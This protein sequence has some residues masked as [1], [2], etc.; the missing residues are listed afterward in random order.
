MVICSFPFLDKLGY[1]PACGL[2]DVAYENAE[3]YRHKFK[4]DVKLMT[5][6]I[7]YVPKWYSI[8]IGF[9]SL[10]VLTINPFSYYKYFVNKNNLMGHLLSTFWLLISLYYL[11]LFIVEFINA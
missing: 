10:L 11:S 7:K 1:A 6:M 3:G 8:V 5:D 2:H 4:L 9:I